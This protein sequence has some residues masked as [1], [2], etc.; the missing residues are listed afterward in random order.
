MR[1]SHLHLTFLVFVVKNEH[2]YQKVLD[3]NMTYVLVSFYTLIDVNVQNYLSTTY[4]AREI[5]INSDLI[6]QEPV[7]DAR[8]ELFQQFKS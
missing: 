1:L 6:K 2:F 3:F 7:R 4:Q 8:L 5:E